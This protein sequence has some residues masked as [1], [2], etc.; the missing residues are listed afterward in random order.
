MGKFAFLALFVISIFSTNC[1]SQPQKLSNT[2]PYT[3]PD[4]DK[5]CS[6]PKKLLVMETNLGTMKI[7]LFD[8]LAPNHVAQIT[9]LAKDGMY[10]GIYFHRVMPG[11]MIQG[12]DPN[13]KDN[14][15]SNDGTGGMGEKLKAE[16]SSVHHARGVCSMARTNDPN[17]ATS[18]FFICNADAG[19][20]DRQY[21]VWGQVVEGYDTLDK[22]TALAD[23]QNYP[24]GDGGH[25]VNPGKDALMTKVYVT[26]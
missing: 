22:I 9:K 3:G 19:G 13:T 18:Q 15:P 17:S 10:N 16:F 21:T 4:L 20:L 26:E 8:R 5:Y 14:D 25:S 12:G 1:M 24:R 23:S 2:A 7:Q 6:N 11:F